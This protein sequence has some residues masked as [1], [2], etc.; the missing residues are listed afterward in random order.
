LLKPRSS[1]KG[2]P[3]LNHSSRN[4]L[5]RSQ[6][7]ARLSGLS[8]SDLVPWHSSPIRC[9]ATARPQLRA[10]R[11]WPRLASSRQPVTRFRHRLR[12]IAELEAGAR[13]ALR[14]NVAT[15][16]RFSQSDE[17]PLIPIGRPALSRHSSRRNLSQTH[18]WSCRLR[19]SI[20]PRIGARYSGERPS[21][22]VASP[23]PEV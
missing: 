5:T 15:K 20:N 12:R 23:M 4:W 22:P 9:A 14:A 3:Q 10:D 7:S 6:I 16:C 18:R 21:E 13:D 2:S 8:R 19:R 17:M 11:P 1:R